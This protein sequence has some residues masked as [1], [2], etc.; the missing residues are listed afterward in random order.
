MTRF[1]CTITIFH[2]FF[3][4]KLKARWKIDSVWFY[5]YDL[6]F[7]KVLQGM[8]WNDINKFKLNLFEWYKHQLTCINV[9]QIING[10]VYDWY[11]IVSQNFN[12]PSHVIA[13]CIP[14]RKLRD[15]YFEYDCLR[16][17]YYVKSDFIFY[18]KK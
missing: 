4:W 9:S 1:H 17:K 18:L 10:S 2:S 6:F 14:S 13:M 11:S 8:S 7:E 16:E 15:K 3:E 12:V 5:D